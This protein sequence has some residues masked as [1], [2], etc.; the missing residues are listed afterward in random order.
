MPTFR[1]VY[2]INKE[3]VRKTEYEK[4]YNQ[5]EPFQPNS[6]KDKNGVGI[7]ETKPLANMKTSM[8]DPIKKNEKQPADREV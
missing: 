7:I 8:V 5:T 2:E 3:P 4:Q 1:D 6:T